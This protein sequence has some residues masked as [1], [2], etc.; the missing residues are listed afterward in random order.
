MASRNSF[1]TDYDF[2]GTEIVDRVKQKEGV[3]P[4]K[5]RDVGFSSHTTSGAYQT[6]FR[7]VFIQVNHYPAFIEL[8]TE[9][10]WSIQKLFTISLY[11]NDIIKLK[12]SIYQYE[13]D[14][15]V[16]HFQPEIHPRDIEYVEQVISYLQYLY[17]TPLIQQQEFMS[18][19]KPLQKIDST[20]IQISESL[21][22]DPNGKSGPVGVIQALE[23]ANLAITHIKYIED[24]DSPYKYECTLCRKY[25][26]EMQLDYP[27]IDA[28]R[29]IKEFLYTRQLWC[30]NCDSYSI[31][32]L[33]I[34]SKMPCICTKC[35]TEFS[36]T[37]IDLSKI[38]QA[39]TPDRFVDVVSTNLTEV[40]T[41]TPLERARD[42]YTAT[43]GECFLIDKPPEKVLVYEFGEDTLFAHIFSGCVYLKVPL[44]NYQYTTSD[45]YEY[46]SYRCM[47]CGK[48]RLTQ[49]QFESREAKI[50]PW[51]PSNVS[52][53]RVGG[54]AKP[55]CPDCIEMLL[56]D[57]EAVLQNNVDDTKIFTHII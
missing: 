37:N 33:L 51:L 45:P 8:Y 3:E 6:N 4:K 39:T 19:E 15:E 50:N 29:F 30:R 27:Q 36:H 57:V 42:V 16:V 7:S 41:K 55:V 24:D 10:P 18:T 44:S 38:F 49:I 34:P 46:H 14:P 12:Q 21:L 25:Y 35:H 53:S 28:N 54:S 32:P 48:Q 52:T 56:S 20:T 22:K 5:P 9:L 23:N 31:V 1:D 2:I 26:Q 11:Q 17:T 43:E 40:T 13:S 47:N